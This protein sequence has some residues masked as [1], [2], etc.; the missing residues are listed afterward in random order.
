MSDN[1]LGSL[2]L[3]ANTALEY[4][5]VGFNSL[6]SLDLSANTALLYLSAYNNNL[7]SLDLGAN[8]SLLLLDVRG[9]NLPLSQLASM[10]P[11]QNLALGAQ[12]DVSLAAFGTQ[13]LAPG[14]GYDLSAEAVLLDTPTR[15]SFEF[16]GGGAATQG[17]NY[18]FSNGQLTFLDRKS[19]VIRMENDSIYSRG[20]IQEDYDAL[21]NP[22]AKVSTKVLDVLPAGSA[23][24]IWSGAASTAWN[25]LESNRNWSY[26][27]YP[28]YYLEGDIVVFDA[29][30]A[31]NVTV[32]AGGLA[33][34]AMSVSAD[35][36][37]FS[38]GAINGTRL[39]LNAAAQSSTEFRNDASF[40]DG[41]FVHAGNTL[42]LGGTLTS[43]AINV[44]SGGS[45]GFSGGGSRGAI[46]V[47]GGG[48][49]HV[50]QGGYAA[51]LSMADGAGFLAFS[52]DNPLLVS[53]ASAFGDGLALSPDVLSS[54]WT[55]GQRYTLLEADP[56]DLAAF[57]PLTHRGG[58][59]SWSML[60][61]GDKLVLDVERSRDFST[62][63]HT[64]NQRHTAAALPGL[65]ANHELRAAFAA[66]GSEGD[67][68]T[69]LDQLSGEG[70][71]TL[72]NNLAWFSRGFGFGNLR[73]LS[74]LNLSRLLRPQLPPLAGENRPQ[75]LATST[76][77]EA[78]G[79]GPIS[80]PATGA[81]AELSG[82]VFSG[83]SPAAMP[84]RSAD[85]PE[86]RVW[87][88]AG[89]GYSRFDSTGGAARSTLQGPEIGG[90]YDLRLPNGF[91]AGLH[92]R[93]AYKDF[94]MKGGRRT[95]ADVNSYSFGL[96][97]AKEFT[98][99]PGVMR[100]TL[101]GAYGLH[102][103]E[104]SRSVRIGGYRDS[105]EADY[106]AQSF[107]I[108]G[109]AAYA[110]SPL[111][112]LML[113]PFAA[114]SWDS[115]HVESF[116]ESSSRIAGSRASLRSSSRTE[117]NFVSLAGLRG[118][119]QLHERLSLDWEAGWMHVYGDRYH[120]A[121]FRM[122]DGTDNFSIRGNR[123]SRDALSLGLGLDISFTDNISLNFGYSGLYGDQESSHG[124][125][126]TLVF[127]F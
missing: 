126:A 98:A 43:G 119:L 104:S 14:V 9:N 71:P 62:V 13:T 75:E 96:Y 23:P 109:E 95:E 65:P 89:G 27:S 110:F 66:L 120:D 47:A 78:T 68:H 58:L 11:T 39:D 118:A 121:S 50:G 53:G 54:T 111:D 69:G 99:G 122:V 124:G 46:T 21:G 20:I 44:Q 74:S 57:T 125:A 26:N 86:H 76:G 40:R 64:S 102:D 107:Q 52:G 63:A 115:L 5:N 60:A 72:S 61:D 77:P 42:L 81:G 70:H 30:G 90:G 100:L 32:D 18:T 17:T 88:T 2:D 45:L 35:G 49:L 73:R 113:E 101:G 84:T 94:D 6:V 93:Y 85:S 1:N 28:V 79:S 34:A 80:G 31:R 15:F 91:M 105:M 123:V 8:T 83:L 117:D 114:L 55:E 12:T 36:Y 106:T 56:A 97:A 108:Y 24:I 48:W 19:Y 59:L 103:I 33:P 29:G 38:G 22:L 116:T 92:F 25:S 67:I 87:A 41:A 112:K 37:V 82:R 16:A 127:S 7:G 3:S 51:S 4:L 10:M